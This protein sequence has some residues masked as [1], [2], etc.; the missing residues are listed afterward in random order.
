MGTDTRSIDEII[1]ADLARLDRLGKTATEIAQ[2]MQQITDA[3]CR[4][5]G[6]WVKID[7]RRQAMV[8][9]AKGIMVCPWPHPGRFCKRLTFVKNV[10]TG[11]QIRWSDLNIHL[12]G[13]H[14]F[15]EGVG[16]EFRIEPIGLVELIFDI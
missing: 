10:D 12:I 16:S 6:E 1:D 3:A 9:E 11:T 13:E 7:D 2:K 5:L 8:D 14:G 15:F 4:G